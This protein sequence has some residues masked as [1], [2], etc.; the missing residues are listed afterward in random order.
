MSAPLAKCDYFGPIDSE[1]DEPVI[2][3]ADWSGDP[4]EYLPEPY[5]LSEEEKDLAERYRSGDISG[6]YLR[7]QIA[8]FRAPQPAKEHERRRVHL[9][10]VQSQTVVHGVLLPESFLQLAE[11]D[12]D[13]DRIRHNTIWFDIFPSLVDFPASPKWKLLQC[14]REG[15]GCD[16]WSL[17]LMTDGSHVVVYHSESLDIK[18]NYPGSGWKPDIASY[19]FFQ[20]GRSFDEW[21]AVYFLDCIRGDQHYAEMLE[22][23]P[24]M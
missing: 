22:K 21:L 13:V 15:Q 1:D 20:C 11:R 9:A 23:Y 24:G 17:L 5:T 16:Y 3:P 10:E 18:G 19:E 12:D 8:C 4:F 14:F 2:L 7:S 6:G